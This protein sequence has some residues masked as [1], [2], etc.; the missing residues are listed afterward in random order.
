MKKN[1]LITLSIR[2]IKKTI[3]RFLSLAVLSFLGVMVFVGVKMSNLDMLKSLTTYYNE[4]NV[5]DL[6]I[7]ST[8]GLTRE[9]LTSISNLNNNLKAY[10]S[11][12]KD[13]QFYTENKSAVIR[14][15]E[16][17]NDVNKIIIDEGKMPKNN[18]EIIIERG[19]TNKLGLKLGDKINLDISEEDETVNAR[20][21]TI[22]G[23]VTSPIYVL[24]SNGNINRGNTNLGAGS[25]NYYGY[26]TSDFFNVDYFTEIY[27]TLRNEFETN[28]NEYNQEIGQLI[29][30]I[31]NIKELRENARKDEISK[32]ML[33]QIEEKENDGLKQFSDIKEQLD[34]ANIELKNGKKKLEATETQLATAKNQLNSAKTVIE[35]RNVQ[36]QNGEEQLQEVKKELDY[37]KSEIENAVAK[38]NLTYDDLCLII[39]II[40]GRSLTKNEVI[41]LVPKDLKYY[42]S[43]ISIINYIYDNKFEKALKNFI[44]EIDKDELINLIP[45]NIEKYNEIVNYINELDTTKI[46][47]TIILSFLNEKYIDE[48]KSKIPVNLK[49]YDN[50]IK[51]LNNYE[52]LSQK[53]IELFNGIEKL[54]SAF[55]I[56]DKK[57]SLFEKSKSQIE[58]AQKQYT[59]ALS[60]Y[61]YGVKEYNNGKK[62]YEDSLNLY[63]SKIEE[64]NLN[65]EKF[66]NEIQ[67]AKN[68]ANSINYSKWIIYNRM[69][70]SD[71]TSYIDSSE[72]VERLAT[73]FPT[74]FFIVAIFISSLS[75]ARMAIE[76][77][78][79]IG[80]LKSLGY[81]NMSIRIIY[82]FY[83][84]FATII[85]GTFGAVAGFF[86]LPKVI[87]NT[88][89]MMYEIPIFAYSNNFIPILLG[90]AIS[91]I[92]ICGTTIITINGLIKEKTN[93]LLRPLSPNKG[94][95]ILLEKIKF[96]WEKLSFSNKITIRNIFRYK[97]RVGMTILG[98]V[99]C[100]TLLLSGYAIRDSIVNIGN[101]H[102]GEIF[103]FDEMLYLD[104]ELDENELNHVVNNHIKERLYTKM[105]TVEVGTD[106]ANL[107]VPN[108]VV[109]LEKIVKLKDTETKERIQIESNKVVVSSKLAK[110]QKLKINDKIEFID[111]QNNK[112][113][114][115]VSG[116]TENYVGNYIYMDKQTY[117]NN[118]NKFNINVC[119]LKFDDECDEEVV[120]KELLQSNSNILSSVSSKSVIERF[121]KIF[122]ALDNVVIILVILSGVL[123]FVVLYNLVYVSISERQREIATL[124][125]LGFNNREID[126]YIIKEET[127]I[128]IIGILIG[129]LVGKWFSQ[130]IVETLE[131][132]IVQFVKIIL[133]KSYLLTFS[134]MV[135]FKF[136]VNLR[137]HFTL[138]KI[139][140]IES[141]KSIE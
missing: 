121:N 97:K 44:S 127:I 47:K 67:K 106:S 26:T 128:S 11:H 112:Y 5:Y 104:G 6:K 30:E 59:S 125:V 78:S 68:K 72:S 64:Y 37:L 74:I 7:V 132:N 27:V 38:Y 65:L 24:N 88:Y 31:N 63:N 118:I 32:I 111:N 8:L 99:G 137:V 73:I 93:N 120:T 139:D 81:D 96:I 91:L 92:C 100:T 70:N 40:E 13:V 42:D 62:I 66:N 79:E 25:I 19:I 116:I 87:F 117:E 114:F 134:F 48:I 33:E 60:K 45:N 76:D 2:K 1:R 36:I 108:N 109:E 12:S 113:S 89:E 133:L 80:I 94:K 136:I 135:L 22:V 53:I 16:I 138:K 57:V 141:L 39:E 105:S 77:R 3:R 84:S 46:R 23:I 20:E 49:S 122:G 17:S 102:F 103:V 58:E 34:S 126:L 35:E 85:G 110:R 129:L 55:D 86:Y 51:A 21:L 90:I 43:I 101:K 54:Q 41:A 18:S 130:I 50:I 15:M 28:S 83:A 14:I 75:M 56:Y 115:V 69:D 29:N 52:L 61:N 131:V 9:D 71:Y 82:I 107:F 4:N 140:M 123:S 124:K 98:I 10:G 95:K 119:Y